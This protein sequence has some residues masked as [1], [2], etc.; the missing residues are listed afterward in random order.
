MARKQAWIQEELDRLQGPSKRVKREVKPDPS[1][2]FE[3]G[4]DGAIDLTSDWWKVFCSSNIR[5]ITFI[6]YTHL[7]GEVPYQNTL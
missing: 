1:L 2:H 7:F 4:E 5:S 6:R 3:V